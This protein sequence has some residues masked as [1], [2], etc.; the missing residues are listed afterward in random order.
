MIEANADHRDWPEMHAV[1]QRKEA[2]WCAAKGICD[3]VVARL[4]QSESIAGRR[5]FAARIFRTRNA[6]FD[7][8]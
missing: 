7:L 1:S 8:A 4:G 6:L 2:K 3:P 5:A